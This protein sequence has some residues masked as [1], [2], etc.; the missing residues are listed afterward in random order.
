MKKWLKI[1]LVADAFMYL[2][3]GMFE[4]IYAIF[5]E[6][7]GGDILTASG[8]WAAFTFTSGFLIWLFGKWEDRVKHLEKMIFLGYA[9]RSCAFLGYFFVANKFHLFAVQILL[10]IG[11][12]TS[13][14]AYDALYSKLLSKGRFASEWGAWEGVYMMVSAAAAIT[15]G[16]IAN[17]FGFKALFLVMFAS[18][19]VGLFA[20]TSLFSKGFRKSVKF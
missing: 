1:L 6:K 16:A 2:A 20:S 12:A 3:A 11:L 14:P 5:V 9:L 10:G 18:S 4:P 19:L 13:L 8:A 7:I 17:F 15:G